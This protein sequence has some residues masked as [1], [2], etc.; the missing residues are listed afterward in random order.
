[1]W[2]KAPFAGGPATNDWMGCQSLE[3]MAMEVEVVM[4][5]M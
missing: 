2:S 4:A 5:M 1:M 3:W